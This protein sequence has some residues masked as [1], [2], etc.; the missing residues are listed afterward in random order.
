MFSGRGHLIL[1]AFG[2]R[3]N[4]GS[5]IAAVP[6]WIKLYAE[7]RTRGKTAYRDPLLRDSRGAGHLNAPGDRFSIAAARWLSVWSKRY[8]VN[9]CMI[10][11][12]NKPRQNTRQC[13]GLRLI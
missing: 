3:S 1:W 8:K 12:C 10:G 2:D 4:A 9:L 5:K 7:Y 6:Q 13:D 11:L